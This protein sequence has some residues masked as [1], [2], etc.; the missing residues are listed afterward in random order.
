VLV[1]TVGRK[2]AFS[3]KA[4]NRMTALASTS[5]ATQLSEKLKKYKEESAREVMEVR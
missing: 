4:V 5:D 1:R 2:A 3:I